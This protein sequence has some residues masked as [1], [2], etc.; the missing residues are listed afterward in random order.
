MRG[1]GWWLLLTLACILVPAVPGWASELTPAIGVGDVDFAQCQAFAGERSLGAAPREVLLGLL[2]LGESAGE[3]TTGQMEGTQRSFRVAFSNPVAIGTLCTTYSGDGSV[4]W[5]GASR[6]QTVSYLKADAPY[7]GDVTVD[8]QWVPL[9][10]GLV[11]TLAP[12]TRTRALRFREHFP[13]PSP[14]PP[15]ATS[16]R[17]R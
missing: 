17:R 10:A 13:S 3:W 11:K 2:G 12:G 6:E 1:L 7:P 9:P 15:P 4:Y 5:F 8:A 16:P 14:P